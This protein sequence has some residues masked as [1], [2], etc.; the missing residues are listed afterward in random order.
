MKEVEAVGDVNLAVLGLDPGELVD[1]L[2][3]PLVHALVANVHLRVEDPQEAEALLGEN[4][5]GDVHDLSV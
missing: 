5:D 2:V 3:A 4:L 1:D